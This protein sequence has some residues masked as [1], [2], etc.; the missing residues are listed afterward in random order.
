MNLLTNTTVKYLTKLIDYM[1]HQGGSQ[2]LTGE[3]RGHERT[4][5][6]TY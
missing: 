5:E 2:D 4:D 6:G 1:V 3:A